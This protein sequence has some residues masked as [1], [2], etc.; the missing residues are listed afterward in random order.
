MSPG[1][2]PGLGVV[3]EER[4]AEKYPYESAY[5]PV[6]HKLDGTLFDW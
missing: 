4:L 3:L 1:N 2:S 5:L 6:N